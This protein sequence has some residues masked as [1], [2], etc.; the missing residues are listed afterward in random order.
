MPP[1]HV[2]TT[3]SNPLR[4]RSR[5]Q[6][7]DDFKERALAAGAHLHVVELAYGERPFEVTRSDGSHAQYAR[8]HHYQYRTHEELWH[9]E[10]LINLGIKRALLSY[11]D[12]R[13]FAWVDADVQF[14]RADW[15]EET[16]HQLQHYKVVQM[17]TH[18]IDLG[19]N[20]QPIAQHTG[21]VYTWMNS[22]NALPSYGLGAYHPGYAWAARID[23]LNS[24]GGLIDY[25]ILGSADSHMAG[26]FT[27]AVDKTFHQGMSRDYKDALWHYQRLCDKHLRQKIG[28]VETSL[29]H[30]WHGKKKDR[31]YTNRWRVLSDNG[32]S[33]YKDITRRAD[34]LVTLTGEKRGLRDGLMRYFRSRAEDSIDL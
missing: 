17:W 27:G 18:A 5:I 19:P 29:T 2:I 30:E 24:I 20:H 10:N 4:F 8:C 7:F 26:A 28:Y 34:G 11:P 12:A 6:L 32:F 1:L 23:A 14:T 16:V 13:Y 21:Y 25:A 33:P 22:A 3:V 9:K 31:G 15:V